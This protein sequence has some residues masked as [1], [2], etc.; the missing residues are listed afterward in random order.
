[1]SSN[2]ELPGARQVH[3][4]GVAGS[5]MAA[6]ASL[7]LQQGKR[8]SGSDLTTTP[9]LA[10]LRAAGVVVANHHAAQNLSEDVDYVIHS[11]AVPLS[12]PEVAEATRRG[13][14]T[15]KLAE[16]VGELMRGRSGVAIAGTHGKTTTTAL[17]TWLLDQGG[18]D[19]LAL[20]GA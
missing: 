15:R 9:V 3:M 1:M 5:G 8:V 12:N 16:A 6:L 20:I 2:R 18:L 4:V 11:S 10:E 13:L 14:P 7:L 17:V 19:P